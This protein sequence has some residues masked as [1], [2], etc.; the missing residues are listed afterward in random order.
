MAIVHQNIVPVSK[1][2][3]NDQT[4]SVYATLDNIINCSK[5]IY[6]KEGFSITFYEGENAPDNHIKIC[7]DVVHRQGH[8]ETYSYNVPMD[9]KGLKG[10]PNM[11]P[12]HAKASS[13]SYARRYLMCMILNIPTGDDNDGNTI[14]EKITEEQVNIIK[15]GLA[16][17]KKDESKFLLYLGV[18]ALEDL[19]ADQY[20]KAVTAIEEVKAKKVNSE[21]N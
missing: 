18:K 10:N 1:S 12:I 7:A 9:G 4:H 19:P 6:T 8:K 11:I 21:N 16:E 2:A 15:E 13:T 20:Q 5:P 3:K 14:V 17:V